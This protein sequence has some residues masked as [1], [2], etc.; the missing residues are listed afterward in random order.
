MNKNILIAIIVSI[1]IIFTV[2]LFFVFK[3]KPNSLTKP[4]DL[5]R[6]E[7]TEVGRIDPTYVVRTRP[8]VVPAVRVKRTN[9][10]TRYFGIFKQPNASSVINQLR[11]NSAVNIIAIFGTIGTEL[12]ISRSEAAKLASSFS[13]LTDKPIPIQKLTPDANV[14]MAVSVWNESFKPISK[15]NYERT[16]KMD[17]HPPVPFVSP[18]ALAEIFAKYNILTPSDVESVRQYKQPDT[19]NPVFVNAFKTYSQNIQNLVKTYDTQRRKVF[20]QTQRRLVDRKSV[21]EN[22]EIE[23]GRGI[24][25]WLGNILVSVFVDFP[26]KVSDAVSASANSLSIE[27]IKAIGYL[28]GSTC[29]KMTGKVAVGVVFIESS[30]P[31]EPVFSDLDRIKLVANLQKGHTFLH[32]NHP[33]PKNLSWNYDWQFTKIDV[34]GKK[35]GS[36]KLDDDYFKDAAMKKVNYNGKTFWGNTLGVNNYIDALKS[37]KNCDHAV[38]FFITPYEASWAAYAIPYNGTSTL[39]SVKNYIGWGINNTWRIFAHETG[40]LFGAADEYSPGADQYSPAILYLYNLYNGCDSTFGCNETPNANFE[41]CCAPNPPNGSVPCLMRSNTV[42]VCPA[43]QGQIGWID[44]Y[45]TVEVT[46]G[47]DWWSGT[48]SDVYI[49]FKGKL[50]VDIEQKLDIPWS[51][52][53][54]KGDVQTYKLWNSNITKD[55]ILDTFSVELRAI[56]N[57]GPPA[58]VIDLSYVDNWKLKR[59]RISLKD[60]LLR[61]LSPNVWL[62][63]PT[64]IWTAPAKAQ[65][66]D[67]PFVQVEITTGTDWWAGTDNNIYLNLFNGNGKS[68]L[69]DSPKNDFENGDI[70]T[71]IISDPN[72]TQD[73]LKKFTVSLM[74]NNFNTGTPV[75]TDNWQLAKVRVWFKNNMIGDYSPNVWLNKNNTFWTSP[76]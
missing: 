30:I 17:Y 39:S 23:V 5:G 53:F 36:S 41:Q 63:K 31:G 50:G 2:T 61:D 59:I 55:V 42:S 56:G 76:I 3:Q 26:K 54:E 8:T 68:Y 18:V 6:L 71:Y 73:S 44:K 34:K 65:S 1:F 19:R 45:V 13:I 7:L 40:H 64:L 48:D 69:L 57:K 12:Y 25:T 20:N 37:D 32:D 74:P 15:A 10:K 22:F 24:P 52:D 38:V 75:F 58:E 72:L 51:N 9:G 14:N 49:H 21:T 62:K 35:A 67:S 66:E 16:G 47:T 27:L 29:K 70:A 28:T 4:S 60:E 33:E 11:S 43:S 46:T